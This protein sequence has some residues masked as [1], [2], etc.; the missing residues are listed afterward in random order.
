MCTYDYSNSSPHRTTALCNQIIRAR[1]PRP[2]SQRTHA[3]ASRRSL[4][5]EACLCRRAG[6]CALHQ[7]HAALSAH[8]APGARSAAPPATRA[9]PR[10]PRR[11]RRAMS[12]NWV[13]INSAGYRRFIERSRESRW[14]FWGATAGLFGA[15]VL[16]ANVTMEITNP[17]L[18]EE[19]GRDHSEQLAKLPMHTQV[20]AQP[21]QA[22]GRV[23]AASLVAHGA[24]LRARCRRWCCWRRPQAQQR[25]PSHTP[26]PAGRSTQAAGA[27]QGDDHRR[28]DRQGPGALPRDAR[29]SSLL[30]NAIKAGPQMPLARGFPPA[31]HAVAA[32]DTGHMAWTHGTSMPSP[33]R[34][35]ADSTQSL[36]T[37]TRSGKIHGTAHG[38]LMP[39]AQQLL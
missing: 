29:V 28:D 4:Y 11:P 10:S 17:G 26:A 6:R 18:D 19:A 25:A 16:A 39:S 13:F 9:A 12:H 35:H 33:Q 27:A 30:P 34:L 5:Q 8:R 23:L 14:L 21:R 3:T 22:R 36:P 37:S 15:A 1:S 38:I 24:A 7:P 31:A 20:R 32:A 2:G